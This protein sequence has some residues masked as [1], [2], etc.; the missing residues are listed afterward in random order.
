VADGGGGGKANFV[1][2]VLGVGGGFDGGVGGGAV[3]EVAAPERHYTPADDNADDTGLSDP[4][5]E[6]D[7]GKS[8]LS[9][10]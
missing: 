1:L 7:A 4:E 6:H 2:G 5:E 10:L 8:F 3:A 9:C